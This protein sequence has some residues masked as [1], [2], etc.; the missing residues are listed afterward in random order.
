M[1]KMNEVFT[2]TLNEHD[3][4][5]CIG[6]H[7]NPHVALSDADK[8]AAHAINC[9]DELVAMLVQLQTEGGLSVAR[10]RQIDRLLQKARGEA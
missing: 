8:A 2:R 6:S 9:H 4:S 1:R 3:I 7:V 5:L 10:H